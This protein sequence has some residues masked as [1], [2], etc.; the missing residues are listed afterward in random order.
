M[1][2]NQ[3]AILADSD[4]SLLVQ[5]LGSHYREFE[6]TFSAFVQTGKTNPKHKI[7]ANRTVDL[8]KAIVDIFIEYLE[9]P[10]KVIDAMR[11]W[12]DKRSNKETKKDIPNTSSDNLVGDLVDVINKD[13]ENDLVVSSDFNDDPGEN[14]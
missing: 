14:D 9:N 8:T 5:Y 2:E 6:A 13:S 11:D 12:D 7:L 3:S 1:E 10:D 4:K